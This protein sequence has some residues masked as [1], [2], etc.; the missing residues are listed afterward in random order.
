MISRKYGILVSSSRV[1][2]CHER[3]PNLLA[4]GKQ[5]IAYVLMAI[6]AETLDLVH[7]LDSVIFSSPLILLQVESKNLLADGGE[8]VVMVIFSAL[9]V[10]VFVGCTVCH[11]ECSSGR[12]VVKR[13]LIFGG[14]LDVKS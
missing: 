7:N 11:I 6:H 14:C 5:A 10:K 1:M 3:Q 8:Q 13:M 4:E 9:R 2:P 12:D